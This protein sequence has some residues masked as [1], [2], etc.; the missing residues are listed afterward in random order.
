MARAKGKMHQVAV[1]AQKE[2]GQVQFRP[3]SELWDETHGHLAFHK[4]QHGMRKHDFHLV[5]FVLHDDT[6]EGLKFPSTPHDAMWV[7]KLEDR[8]N[9][10]CPGP[11][12][13]S[14][15]GVIEPICVSD[16]GNRLIVRNDNPAED[17]WSFTLNFVKPGANEADAH[18]YVS[19]D[20]I[21][22]NGNGGRE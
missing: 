9:P 13:I 17:D 3:G 5:E 18:T 15:Y 8:S 10:V 4:D 1:T 6:G 7:A 14:D 2:G 11:E 19:W 22:R 16:D 21:I 20:P 12:T